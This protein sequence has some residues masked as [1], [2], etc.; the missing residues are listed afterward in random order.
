MLKKL[1]LYYL[2]LFLSISQISFAQQSVQDIV[3]NIIIDMD[4]HSS[5]VLK[6]YFD[7]EAFA[8]R[9]L[10]GLSISSQDKRDLKT[11]IKIGTEQLLESIITPIP[12]DGYVKL[13]RLT[14]HNTEA[15]AVLRFDYGDKG[16][17]FMHFLIKKDKNNIKIIDIFDY[18]VG[19]YNSEKSRQ[20]ILLALPSNSISGR[21]I[22]LAT[23]KKQDQEDMRRLIDLSK[24]K[25]YPQFIKKYQQI[26]P[27]L[28]K[29]IS[30]LFLAMVVGQQDLTLKFYEKVLGDIAH[31]HGQNPKYALMLIDY[32][33]LTKQY[34]KALQSVDRS[35]KLILGN[36][37]DPALMLFKANTY[38]AMTKYKKALNIINQ[39]IKLEPTLEILYTIKVN[40]AVGLKD[41]PMIVNSCQKLTLLFGYQ[42][43]H[44][45]FAA[46]PEYQDFIK[47][48]AYLKWKKTNFK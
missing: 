30:V 1:T 6:Q 12:K 25:K 10:K 17:G 37:Q 23:G 18:M 11:G 47:S 27:S 21:L 26:N 28:K 44:Q 8:N 36:K 19:Q 45:V 13:L 39:A 5:A 20:L 7:K 43:N 38:I 48:T 14:E 40:A 3:E 34:K 41:Y 9:I 2:F 35:Q 24:D 4:Q 16:F 31:Y 15:S 46:K 33:F 29:D 32:Y 42:F 22:D